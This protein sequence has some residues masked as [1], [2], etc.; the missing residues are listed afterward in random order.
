MRGSGGV[1]YWGISSLPEGLSQKLRL[2]NG[3]L[4]CASA[5]LHARKKGADG[6]WGAVYSFKD[7]YEGVDRKDN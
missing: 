2:T 3:I 5:P 4:R 7:E 6:E 1:G